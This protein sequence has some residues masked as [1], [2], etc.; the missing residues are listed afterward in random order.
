MQA[1][2]C[3]YASSEC[4]YIDV[5]GTSQEV[6]AKEVKEIAEKRLGKELAA[7]LDYHVNI[8]SAIKQIHVLVV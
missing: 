8:S 2:S 6:I 7:D 1:I 4:E 5:Q 3:H